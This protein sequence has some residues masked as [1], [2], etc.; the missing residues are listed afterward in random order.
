VD[1]LQMAKQKGVSIFYIS[2]RDSSDIG[3]T[4][5]NLQKLQLPDADSA[6]LL[7]MSSTSAKEPRRQRVMQTHNV[8]MLM[9]DNLN[10]FS[11][12]FEKRPSG[13]RKGVTDSLRGE[14]GKR[15][16]VLPNSMYGEWENAVYD[17]KRNL[18]PAQRESMRKEKLLGF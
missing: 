1:F 14:W 11:T 12:V 6:H 4:L 9:G 8:I 10:D 13:E 3:T 18:S 7:L 17:Y 5:L 16:I 2:N 15:F